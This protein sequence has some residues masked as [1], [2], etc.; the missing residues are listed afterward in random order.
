MAWGEGPDLK[1]LMQRRI[2]AVES[3]FSLN[4]PAVLDPDFVGG[5]L[6]AGISLPQL[7]LSSRAQ[8]GIKAYF[9]FSRDRC[10]LCH[11]GV[12]LD[13]DTFFKQTSVNPE[14]N[15]GIAEPSNNCNRIFRVVGKLKVRT[16]P[17]DRGVQARRCIGTGPGVRMTFID[18]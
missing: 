5:Y 16:A 7:N 1:N 6:L 11:F 2:I 4:D 17:A 15:P 3:N 18:L 9:R 14:I 8:T 12:Q 10:D 13:A